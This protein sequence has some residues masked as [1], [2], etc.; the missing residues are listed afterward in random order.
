MGFKEDAILD[1]EAMFDASELGTSGTYF[2]K[3]TSVTISTVG[4]LERNESL[5]G[6]DT[7]G[8]AEFAQLKIK[9]SAVAKPERYDTWT[10]D[11]ETWTVESILISDLASWTV[12]LSRDQRMG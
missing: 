7:G 4:I 9:K 12:R 1:I 10:S 11:G 3:A 6:W 2:E 8:Q 5:A